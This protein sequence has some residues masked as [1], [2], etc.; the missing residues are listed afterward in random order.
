MSFFID[1][2][3]DYLEDQSIGTVGTNIFVGNL[4][5][6]APDDSVLVKVT[7]GAAPDHYLPT[8]MPSF[9]IY[10]RNSEYSAGTTKVEAIITAIN[11]R[12][13]L[14]LVTGGNYFYYITLE[15]DYGH[16]GRD[17]NE[18]DEFSMN[19]SCLLR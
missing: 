11:K 15:G 7:G 17:E 12:T 9:Q 13:N 16:I 1:D 4:P 8:R 10:V 14:K 5:T 3:A 6:N 2:I 18:R 19:Y